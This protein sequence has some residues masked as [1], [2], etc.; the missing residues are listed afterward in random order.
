MNKI[1]KKINGYDVSIYLTDVTPALASEILAKY[2]TKNRKENANH[3]K[4]ILRN[5]AEGTWRF[6]GDTICFD[7]TGTL[8]DGQHRL[9]AIAKSGKTL[10]CLFV[11][12]LDPETIKTKD[13]EAKPRNL[14]DLFKM[15][16]VGQYNN[17]ASIVQRYFVFHTGRTG[18]ATDKYGYNQSVGRVHTTATYDAKYDFY[19]DNKQLVD[20]VVNYTRSLYMANRLLTMSELGGLSLYLFLD[21]HHSNDE[22]R[23]FLDGFVY[24]SPCN[25]LNLLRNKLIVDKGAVK[26]MQATHKQ[27]LI[28]KTWNYY[29]KGKDVK[30]LAYNPTTEGTIEF[31]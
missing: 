16:G 18:I 25:V 19:Y 29:I 14:G 20:E 23:G 11:V 31:I 15:D 1:S 12:G 28:A 7:S 3:T 9:S 17:V 10:T 8:I 22:I 5:I 27:A 21:K 24:D 30:V 26:K 13:I 2:N 4:A 6:N